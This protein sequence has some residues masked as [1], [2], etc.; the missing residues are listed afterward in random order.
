[1]KDITEKVD[2]QV[3]EQMMLAKPKTEKR[4]IPKQSMKSYK[5]PKKTP[6]PI[7]RWANS[8]N[9]QFTKEAIPKDQQAHEAKLT[10]QMN[11]N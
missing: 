11:V 7:Q 1:M 5:S 2:R 10:F 4:L 6:L 8:R 3:T 9:R